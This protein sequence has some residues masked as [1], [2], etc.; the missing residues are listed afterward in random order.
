MRAVAPTVVRVIVALLAVVAT[1]AQVAYL[2]AIAWHV[3]GLA[4]AMSAQMR[5]PFLTLMTAHAAVSVVSA[6]LAIALVLHEG[7]R[8]AAARGLALALA[9]WSYLT[10]Y[11]GV[12]LLLRNPGGPRDV[13]DAHFLLV[14]VLGLVGI[15]RFAALFPDEPDPAAI[16]P[17]S[18][19]PPALLPL[20]AASVWLLRPAAPWIVGAV[21][22][23]GL[24]TLT[25]LQGRPLGDASLHPAM[26]VVRFGAAGF[27]VLSLR[28]AWGRAAGESA[29]RLTWLLAALVFLLG[30]LLLFIG[31]N[32]LMAVAEWPEPVVAWR[33]LLMDLGLVG[34]LGGLAMAVLYRG[35]LDA[36][37]T[38]G[39][40]AALASIGAFGLFLAAGLEALFGGG[41]MAGFALRT[42]VG[43]VLAIAIVLSTCRGM[44]RAVEL[45]LS[46]VLAP[47]GMEGSPT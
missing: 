16:R 4:P 6:L 44:M 3:L 45:A 37:R 1:V 28:R 29:E 27:V 24:W 8:Q 26:D 23:A 20:H 38:A 46:Q 22:L 40:I 5:P 17:P 30:S 13:F 39:R 15:V 11:S 47:K 41:V 32:V 36:R 9:A 10:A 25:G 14:E 18:T 21:A 34:F 31:G 42:G 12:T 43:T 19:L 35:P 33:P 2:D 7:E